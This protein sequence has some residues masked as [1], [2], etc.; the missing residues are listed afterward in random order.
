[1]EIINRICPLTRTHA[2]ELAVAADSIIK[3]N[4]FF[5]PGQ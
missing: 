4:K 1:M 3:G 5:I 2:L